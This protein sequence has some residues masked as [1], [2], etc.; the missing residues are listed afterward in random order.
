VKLRIA[1]TA[2]GIVVPLLFL[3]QNCGGKTEISPEDLIGSSGSS[4]TG[5][6]APTAPYIFSNKW[7]S[8]T[9][10]PS[11]PALYGQTAT[12]ASNNRVIIWGGV[13]TLAANTPISG[14]YIVDLNTMAQTSFGGGPSARSRHSAVWTGKNLIVWGGYNDAAT[15]ADL[16]DGGIYDPDTKTWTAIAAFGPTPRMGHAAVWTGTEMIIWGGVDNSN[17]PLADGALYNPT[18]NSWRTMSTGGAPSARK[19]SIAVWTGSKMIVWGGATGDGSAVYNNGAAYDPAT[20]TWTPLAQTSAPSV[21][22]WSSSGI[23]SSALMIFGGINSTAALGDGY[24]LDLATGTWSAIS[25]SGA[26]SARYAAAQVM[27]PMGMIVFGGTN[28]TSVFGD[29]AIYY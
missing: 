8:L 22:Q 24:I 20:D 9:T 1:L 3:F 23:S 28:G 27:T 19:H 17:T 16:N 12:L 5:P 26:P 18:T 7:K 6:T 21:R 14:G 10:T 2:F 4:S 15:G 11:L 29:A 25:T 13:N